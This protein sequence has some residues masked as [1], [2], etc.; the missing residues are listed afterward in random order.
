MS[1]SKCKATNSAAPRMP[2]V[3][4]PADVEALSSLT[5]EEKALALDNL[6]KVPLSDG[7]ALM[8]NDPELQAFMHIIEQQ[9]TALLDGDFQCAP[10]TPM[11]LV[12]LEAVRRSG[13][14]YMK[15]LFFAITAVELREF[16]KEEDYPKL[17]LLDD[18]DCSLWTEEERLVLKFAQAVLDNKMTDEL[19]SQ[20]R[21]AWG[22]KKLLRLFFW[23]GYVNLWGLLNNML[24]IKFTP[25]M[26]TE[27][28]KKGFPP[29]VIPNIVGPFQKTRKD[30]LEFWKTIPEIPH[31]N[32]PTSE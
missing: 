22:D 4:T 23:M 8:G 29:A 15:T 2:M 20:A 5:E 25:D 30:L 12:T 6:K 31:M 18:P 27:G 9:A 13:N 19:F 28:M 26:M 1:D 3:K 21:T 32:P 10:L 7:W 14:D 11:N 17:G 16:N 24:N